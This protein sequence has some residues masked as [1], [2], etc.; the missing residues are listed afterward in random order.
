M[1]LTLLMMVFGGLPSAQAAEP[2]IRI[3]ATVTDLGSLAREVGGDLVIV[4]VMAKGREDPHFLEAKPS[5]IK[6]LNQADL[7]LQVGMEL[8]VGYAPLL[9]QNA[10]NGRILP[11]NPGH[12]DCSVAITPLEVPAGPVDRSMGD[13]HPYGNPHYLLDPLNGLKVA[14]LIRDR[15]VQL[16]AER[17]PYVAD[18]YAAFRRRLETALVG[19]ALA[20]KYDASKLALLFELGKL[21]VFL[22]Q[23][24]DAEKLGGWLGMMRGHR[25]AKVVDDHNL[26]PYFTRRFGLV[27]AGHLEPKPGIPPTTS[28]LTA[29]I[30]RM[31]AEQVR[32]ILAA[33]YYDPRHARFVAEASGATVVYLAHQVGGREGAGNYLQMVDYNVR[34]VAAALDGGAPRPHGE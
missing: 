6:Q 4:D 7:Y 3:F 13:V 34:Q 12:L 15:L 10:R 27:L 17:G 33:P 18:R 28:H 5:F 32:L 1:V 11:G 14:A 22:Q 30:D 2:P 23:Q 31:R 19:E 20:E 21:D 24:G 25:G 29:L 16:R 26:W 9:L 8:E